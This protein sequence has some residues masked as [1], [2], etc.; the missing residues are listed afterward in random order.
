MPYT[1]KWLLW[2]ILKNDPSNSSAPPGQVSALVQALV[3][4]NTMSLRG[5]T[6][7]ILAMELLSPS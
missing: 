6:L 7:H 2:E 1:R 5:P 4:H 3:G